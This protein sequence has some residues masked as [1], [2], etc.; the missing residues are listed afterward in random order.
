[1]DPEPDSG[2][3]FSP[4]AQNRMFFMICLTISLALSQALV[5]PYLGD[6]LT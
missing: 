3:V 2:P 1:M 6:N 4:M 5:K